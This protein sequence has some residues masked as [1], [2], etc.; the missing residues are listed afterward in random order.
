MNE[1][2]ESEAV[3]DQTYLPFTP[4]ELLEHFAPVAGRWR[5]QALPRTT[6]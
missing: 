3:I 6:K 2:P 5:F 1:S 4:T